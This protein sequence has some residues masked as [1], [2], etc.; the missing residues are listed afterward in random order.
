MTSDHTTTDEFHLSGAI[1]DKLIAQWKD[2]HEQLLPEVVRAEADNH[3][4]VPEQADTIVWGDETVLTVT[5]S[6]YV[7]VK[8]YDKI[9]ANTDH[10]DSDIAILAMRDSYGVIQGIDG[11]YVG[12]TILLLHRY[13]D[14]DWDYSD[15]N[16]HV[17]GI[18]DDLE[19][20]IDTDWHAQAV[21]LSAA[22]VLAVMDK[23]KQSEMGKLFE[24]YDCI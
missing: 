1:V 18:P 9:L 15:P 7:V 24:N 21:W 16:V 23:D 13:P 5:I 20:K 4:I 22:A 14:G 12:K 6:Q 10:S 8:R 2:T 19:V 3:A 11:V 17:F